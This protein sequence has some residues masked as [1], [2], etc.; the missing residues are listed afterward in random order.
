ML[1]TIGASGQFSLGKK[2]A[3]KHFQMEQRQDG[4]VLLRPVTVTPT[5]QAAARVVRPRFHVVQVKQI[6][7][8]SRDQ[9]HERKPIR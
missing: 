5:G 1:K 6:A 3:G 2:Y 4:S 8:L 9:L 7:H